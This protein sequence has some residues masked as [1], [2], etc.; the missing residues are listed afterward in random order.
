MSVVTVAVVL[1]FSGP[2]LVLDHGL[3]FASFFLFFLSTLSFLPADTLL[4]L[5]SFSFAI[6]PRYRRYFSDSFCR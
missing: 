6:V 1:A 3:V 2:M 4:C 5:F